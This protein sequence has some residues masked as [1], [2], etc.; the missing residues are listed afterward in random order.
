MDGNLR[1]KGEI[2]AQ[3]PHGVGKIVWPSGDVYSG[4]FRN[5]KR[6]GAGKRVNND[7]SVFTGQYEED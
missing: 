1:Y 6:H 2:R 3:V 5:G 4:E 7:G